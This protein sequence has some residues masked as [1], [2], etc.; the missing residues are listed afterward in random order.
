MFQNST[1]KP[2]FNDNILK[3]EIENIKNFIKTY[4]TR[5]NTKVIIKTNND[6]EEILE[7]LNDFKI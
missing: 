6:P 7:K 5:E 3:D 1:T 4:Y 2:D